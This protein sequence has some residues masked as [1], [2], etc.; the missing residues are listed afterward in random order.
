[1]ARRGRR[2]LQGYFGL[3]IVSTNIPINPNLLVGG[4]TPPLQKT[5]SY[6]VG[7]GVLDDPLQKKSN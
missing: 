4:E 5:I 7:V 1:M 2:S 6:T 3:K